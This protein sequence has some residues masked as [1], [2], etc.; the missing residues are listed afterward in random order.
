VRVQGRSGRTG[1]GGRGTQR[2]PYPAAISFDDVREYR[3]E[4]ELAR[5]RIGTTAEDR[6]HWVA[7]FARRDLKALR[8]GERTALGYDLRALVP[9]GW[10]YKLKKFGPLP[11]DE[12]VAIQAYLAKGLASLL[13]GERWSLPPL[14]SAHLS[15]E[16]DDGESTHRIHLSFEG[17]E[18]QA[19]LGGVTELLMQ[20]GDRLREC[21]ECM[22]PFVGREGKVYCSRACSQR[23]RDQRKRDKRQGKSV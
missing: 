16:Q 11:E 3:R 8:P 17:D 20:A 9:R 14:P 15:R 5:A 13:R 7:E 22:R 12:L 4:A 6:L 18:T 23:I 1:G 10:R 19:I 21:S 2:R